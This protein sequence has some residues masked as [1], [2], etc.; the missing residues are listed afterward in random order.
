MCVIN[1]KIKNIKLEIKFLLINARYM[2]VVIKLKKIRYTYFN[3]TYV[4]TCV[5]NSTKR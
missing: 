1:I 5:C 3:A 2:C 4:Y